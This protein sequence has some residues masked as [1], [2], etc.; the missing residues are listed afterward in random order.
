MPLPQTLARIP[1]RSPQPAATP[2][3]QAAANPPGVVPARDA[4][5]VYGEPADDFA[6]RSPQ[7][8]IRDIWEHAVDA[9]GK[10]G[11]DPRVLVAQSALETGWGKKIIRTGSGSS[12][13]NLFGIKAGEEWQG[14]AAT[15]R[16]LEF[17]DGVAALEKAAF[18]VYD[19][20]AGSFE[21]YVDFLSGNPRYRSALDNAP[22]SAAFLH[23][24]QDAGYATD[25]AYA[26]KIMRIVN[27]DTYSDVF[28][29]LKNSAAVSLR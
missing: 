14:D 20:L 6:P 13:F 18:R 25:P 9:A 19:S 29:E 10:L 28:S 11:V 24:L 23:G 1:S 8:F 7:D 26:A 3:A 17:R 4:T 22:D 21:D 2:T 5:G 16:T 27:A 15:V 12:S